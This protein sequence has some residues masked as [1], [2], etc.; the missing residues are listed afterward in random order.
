L[1]IGVHIEKYNQTE[2]IIGDLR[3]L[4]ESAWDRRNR[5][6]AVRKAESLV[7]PLEAG[8]IC[9]VLSNLFH[10]GDV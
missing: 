1:H 3:R 7:P 8:I 2:K 6:R 10:E 4:R 9:K 5:F